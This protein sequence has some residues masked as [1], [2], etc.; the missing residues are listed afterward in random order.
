M[1]TPSVENLVKH[2]GKHGLTVERAKL[3]KKL[4]CLRDDA[5]GLEE[6]IDSTSELARTSEYARSCYHSPYTS[7]MWRTTVVLHAIDV[8]MEG[9]GVESLGEVKMSG[10]PF[11]YINYGDTYAT[12]LVYSRFNDADNLFI[13]SYGDVVESNPHLFRE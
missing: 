10:P 11:E 3:I 2:F 12:T 5:E 6:F 1:R 9:Y 8:L 13:S 4:A 7:E